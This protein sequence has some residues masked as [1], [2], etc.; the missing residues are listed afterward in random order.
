MIISEKKAAAPCTKEPLT[1]QQ[2]VDT[3]ILPRKVEI[4]NKKI[5]KELV[6]EPCTLL[7]SSL[8]VNA[9]KVIHWCEVF[10]LDMFCTNFFFS[11]F[12]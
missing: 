3:L 11:L 10:L 8:D 4:S 5:E 7:P 2:Q 6:K 12:M 9:G 1:K